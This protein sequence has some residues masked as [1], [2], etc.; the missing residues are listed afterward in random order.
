[1]RKQWKV[2]EAPVSI[3]NLPEYPQ[4]ILRLLGSRALTDPEKIRDFLTPDYAKLHDPFLFKDMQ[5]TIE[6]IWRAIEQKQ[7]ITIYADYDADAI[8]AL[9]VL[10]LALKKLGAVVDYYIPD[11]FTEGYGLNLEA[12]KSICT[13]TNLIITVDCGVNA[14]EEAL[15]CKSAGVDLI[16]TDHHE[17][18]GDLPEAFSIINPKNPHDEYPFAYLTG[19]GVAFKLT[20]A[21][22]SKVNTGWEKWLLDLVAL[23]T[24]AD[25]QSLTDENRILVSFGLKVLAKTR[26]PGLKAMLE[27]AGL[28]KSD[29]SNR[30]D[31]YTLGFILAPRINAAGRIKHA[32]IAFRL[33]ISEDPREAEQLAKELS[34]LNTHRQN[35]TEQIT[36][37]ARA[38][39]ELIADKKVLLAQGLDWPKGVVGLVAG[40]LA[41][42]FNRP[43]LAMSTVEGIATGS[44]RSVA[45]FD[46]VAA[47]TFAKDLLQKYG[48][49]PQAAGFT[50]AS[51]N[52]PGFHQRL[53]EYAESLNLSV[54]EPTLMIDAETV[55]A[56]ITW[57]NLNYLESM[58]PFGFGNPKPK[59]VGRE[60]ALVDYKTVGAQ[61][62]HLKMRL[63]YG[64]HILSAIA[65]SQGFLTSQLTPG[66]K[67][68]AVFELSSNEWNGN[69]EMQLKVLDVRIIEN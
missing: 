24:V 12:I 6:R 53:L 21:L 36:S 7:T 68:D 67:L 43:V 52:I 15:I 23:G 45:N 33:L 60:F 51:E 14:V 50:L 22:F 11:R 58:S 28:N 56:D 65:F 9:A 30:F 18:T 17:L 3:P 19:V 57:D 49:H 47:L 2:K 38:Q 35:L 10:Y 61:N 34:E 31:T 32:D 44:A 5:R 41:E 27:I 13:K 40:R 59:L 63:K 66:K 20:Q 54:D 25:L 64:E 69:K 46:I 39:I 4:L 42:E 26:W 62:Q 8:T 1:M 16:I 37:E 55:P 48:G 29:K